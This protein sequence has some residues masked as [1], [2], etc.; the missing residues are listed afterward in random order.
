MSLEYIVDDLKKYL[1]EYFDIRSDNINNNS[2]IIEDLGADSL[3]LVSLFAYIE[4]TY[5]IK[6]DE[7]VVLK[8]VLSVE[9]V[10]K[11]ILLKINNK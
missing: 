10:A 2:L 11:E 3:A 4:D 6:F 7:Q 5:N 9:S 8:S 1:T